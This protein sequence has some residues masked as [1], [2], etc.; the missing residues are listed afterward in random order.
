MAGKIRFIL[1]NQSDLATITATSEVA[2]LPIE[3]VQNVSRSRVWRSTGTTTQTI[4]GT[5]TADKT[6]SAV[7]F[8]RHNLAVGSTITINLRNS[9][10]STVKTSGA[11]SIT[12]SDAYTAASEIEYQ[13]IRNYTWY[14]ED[15]NGDK[16]SFT[17]I[18]SYQIIVALGTSSMSF[19]ECGRIIVGDFIE[20]TYNLSYGHSL[21]LKEETKQFRTAS[22]TLRSDMAWPYKI[23]SFD[24]GVINETDRGILLEA[25][26][27]IGLR[28]DFTLS[29][30]PAQTEKIKNRDY[31]AIMKL[32]S[33]P[34]FTEIQCNWYKSKCSMEEV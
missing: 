20:P 15:A 8:G 34:S 25:F 17:N 21:G 3:N 6:I 13:D 5:F 14:S 10:G 28:R 24:L 1:H 9:V 12:A 2:T 29:V 11:I 22:G 7:T 26:A 33:M 30:F 4:T 27:D 32:N 19:F 31:T 18:R 23:F 16:E